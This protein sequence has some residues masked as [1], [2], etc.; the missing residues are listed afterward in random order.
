MNGAETWAVEKC[1]PRR[2]RPRMEAKA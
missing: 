2:K 1:A